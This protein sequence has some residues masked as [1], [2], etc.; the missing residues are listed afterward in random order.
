M[1]EWVL[2]IY[3]SYEGLYTVTQLELI[4]APII[5]YI[6]RLLEVSD[7]WTHVGGNGRTDPLAI[8]I[9]SD[10]PQQEHSGGDC[11]VFTLYFIEYL[12]AGVPFD[13]GSQDGPNMRR[14]LA[15]QMWHGRC[16]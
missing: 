5:H 13:F 3:D 9:V 10:L 8:H 15:I 16:L 6:P 14:R 11:G 1:H 12:S 2:N 4:C 7:Y